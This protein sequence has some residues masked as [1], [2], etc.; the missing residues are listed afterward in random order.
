MVL[1]S[2]PGTKEQLTNRSVASIVGVYDA[3]W[4]WRVN[5]SNMGSFFSQKWLPHIPSSEQQYWQC[6]IP[7][8]TIVAKNH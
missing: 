2:M 8:C 7:F 4:Q 3:V 1:L 6:M 5:M